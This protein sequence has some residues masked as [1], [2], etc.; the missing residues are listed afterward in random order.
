[1]WAVEPIGLVTVMFER[2]WPSSEGYTS[3]SYTVF[4]G[5]Q[6]SPTEVTRFFSD[7][8]PKYRVRRDTGSWI[9]LR[10]SEGYNSGYLVAQK[11]KNELCLV[12][13]H[14]FLTIQIGKDHLVS[15]DEII[16]IPLEAIPL[17]TEIIVEFIQTKEDG[18][19]SKPLN[20]RFVFSGNPEGGVRY[21]I[22]RLYL[23]ETY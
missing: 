17:D 14:H 22:E 11:C 16:P 3:Y 5:R 20:R 6:L 15:E 19:T 18:T 4:R 2:D 13:Y 7:A 23:N 12:A 8:G 21:A 10:W 9:E 1:M